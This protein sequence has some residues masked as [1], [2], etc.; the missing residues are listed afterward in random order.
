MKRLLTLKRIFD[1]CLINRVKK[2]HFCPASKRQ[3]LYSPNGLLPST[4][5]S[6]ILLHGM[7]CQVYDHPPAP[8][9]TIN[10]CGP[11]WLSM[12]GKES[13]MGQPN[14]HSW[15]FWTTVWPLPM[16]LWTSRL[17]LQWHW[18]RW[19][20]GFPLMT[21]SIRVAIALT[22]KPDPWTS[23][24]TTTSSSRGRILKVAVIRNLFVLSQK[25]IFYQGMTL[26]HIFHLSV[27]TVWI[28]LTQPIKPL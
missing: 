26:C 4:Q 6:M 27:L 5:P 18:V 3:P 7:L 12:I 25:D 11:R 21:D 15:A 16:T 20:A 13:Q 22:W 28:Q 10:L 14:L 17:K 24:W 8:Y 19:L 9:Q 1:G 23:S 2:I